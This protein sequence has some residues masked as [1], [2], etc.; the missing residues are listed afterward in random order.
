M[1]GIEVDG[2]VEARDARESQLVVLATDLCV[3]EEVGHAAESERGSVS[4]VLAI[5]D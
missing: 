5:G 2:K 3:A 1:H 4:A